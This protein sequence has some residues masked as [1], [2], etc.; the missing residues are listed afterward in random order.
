MEYTTHSKPENNPISI[1]IP[2]YNREHTLPRLF[3][4]LER[5]C[6][7]ETTVILID[8]C[9]RDRSLQL[10]LDF[11]RQQLRKGR[12]NV[13]VD[14]E[15]TRGACACRNHGLRLATT[16][17]VYFFDSDDEI[18][19]EFF[20]DASPYFAGFDL[21]CAPTRMVFAD[22][23]QK[24]RSCLP[25]PY[26]YDHILAASLSTQSFLVRKSF[27]NAAGGWDEELLRWNDWELG[28]RLLCLQPR[29]HWLSQKGYHAIHQHPQSI[30][31]KSFAEDL[32][33]LVSSL[34]KAELD[35]RRHLPD[36]PVL[37]RSLNALAAKYLMLAALL[38]REGAEHHALTVR[39]AAR[40]LMCSRK[41]RAISP[42]VYWLARHRVPGTWRLYRH[43]I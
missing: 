17:W 4:S 16:E 32:P 26:P 11:G 35:V 27:L 9:S 18:S 23:T 21:I 20:R 31:G 30:S 12:L 22:G 42:I 2:V 1:I 29:V 40:Q 3:R 38:C 34:H 37:Q 14:T 24:V 13:R 41:F 7:E 19:P 10:C 5:I 33:Q 6:Q 15:T 36:G 28:V 43:L 39:T 8:N 25:T